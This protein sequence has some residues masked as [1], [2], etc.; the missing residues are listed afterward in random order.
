[1]SRQKIK[2]I[3]GNDLNRQSM[4]KKAAAIIPI[5]INFGPQRVSE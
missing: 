2:T 3:S 1:M 5:A 4:N